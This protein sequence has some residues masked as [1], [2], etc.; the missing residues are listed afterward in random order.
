MGPVAGKDLINVSSH[1]SQR[2]GYWC[3]GTILN[4]LELSETGG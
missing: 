1:N 3:Q 4:I 2:R